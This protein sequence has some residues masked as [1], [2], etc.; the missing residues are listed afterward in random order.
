MKK[1]FSIIGM[2]VGMLLVFLGILTVSGVFGNGDYSAGASP[3][4]SGYA[5]FGGD[6]YTYSVNNSA[7]TA[8][9]AKATASNLREIS[10]ILKNGIGFSMMSMGL[11]AF[12]GFGIVFS[13]CVKKPE[14]TPV[15]NVE[16][17]E[18]IKL[19]ESFDKEFPERDIS[20]EENSPKAT[21]DPFFVQNE[22]NI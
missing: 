2:A 4:D 11:F 21:A 1:K 13:D 9:A 8:S 10:D 15:E 18:E 5:K 22:K 3:Y 6:Y 14:E 20:E 7:E 19:L 16:K 12:C 17:T